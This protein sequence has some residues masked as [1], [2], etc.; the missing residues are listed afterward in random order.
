MNEFADILKNTK[1]KSLK[2]RIR[3]KRQKTGTDQNKK[4]Q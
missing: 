3:R 2:Q 4:Y 1:H